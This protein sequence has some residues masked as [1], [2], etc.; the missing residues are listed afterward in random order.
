VRW[1][2]ERLPSAL[3]RG[4]RIERIRLEGAAAER[5]H[6]RMVTWMRRL[7]RDDEV[8]ALFVTLDGLAGG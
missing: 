8:V 2:D 4:W 5:E 3:S 1:S 6:T 7:E